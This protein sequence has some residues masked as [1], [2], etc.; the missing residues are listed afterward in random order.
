MFS[1]SIT[2]AL[3]L[4]AAQ[5]APAPA[6]PPDVDGQEVVVTADVKRKERIQNFVQALSDEGVTD[7]LARFDYDRQELCPAAVGLGEAQDAAITAR[8]R[9]VA[10]AANIRLADAGC[11]PNALVIFA[12]DRDEMVAALRKKHPVYFRNAGGD[13]IRLPK[14]KGPAIA[15]H[16]EGRVDRTG[17][18]VPYNPETGQYELSSPITPSRISAAM[19]PVILGAVVVIDA[20]AVNGLT[21]T[22]VADYAAMR[23]YARTDP[24]RAQKSGAPTILAALDAPMDTAVP[25]TL[26]RW[27]M[28]YLQGFYASKANHGAR[29]QRSAIRR[30]VGDDLKSGRD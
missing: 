14:E 22:Q 15:W 8:M 7:P 2:A 13:F 28:S 27:D 19:R 16:L 17:S 23:A 21:T 1:V 29:A 3:A 11:K 18:P 9:V 10:K 24:K 6:P 26:T 30:R 4:Q 20:D 25:L 12:P 5:P